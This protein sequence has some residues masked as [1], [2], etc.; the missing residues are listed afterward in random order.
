MP[1]LSFT[2]RLQIAG[3]GY[4]VVT[5]FAAAFWALQQFKGMSSTDR[6]ILSAAAVA[7]ILL[8]LLWERI[9]GLKVGEVEITMIEVTLPIDIVLAS[10][11]QDLPSAL[12]SQVSDLVQVV[13]PALDSD[14]LKIVEINLRDGS[15][16]WSTRLHLLAALA[17]EYTSIDRL[18]FVEQNDA[19]KYLGM[20]S[21][22]AVRKA[23][24][25]RFFEIERAFREIQQRARE[26]GEIPSNHVSFIGREWSE[27]SF[28][29]ADQDPKISAYESAVK[30]IVTPAKLSAWLGGHLETD[31]REWDGGAVTSELCA[32]ILSCHGPYV[33]LLNR[34]RLEQVV[35]RNELS[36]RLAFSVVG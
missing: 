32:K 6:L 10:A 1:P 27:Y 15:Y 2:R 35:D 16:W 33:P 14:K 11:I 3:A 26:L 8:A 13:G 9:K 18:I 17:D 24:A 12:E 36:A 5:I 25:G 19:R 34:E 22:S 7:P 30:E 20:A 31:S 29:G 21:P 4:V 28:R 23:L